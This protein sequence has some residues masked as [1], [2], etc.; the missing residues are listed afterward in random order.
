MVMYTIGVA[1]RLLFSRLTPFD[2]ERRWARDLARVAR[3][4]VISRATH[5]RFYMPPAVISDFGRRGRVLGIFLTIFCP[6]TLATSLPV[7][8]ER[9]SPFDLEISA[10]LEHQTEGQSFFVSWNDIITLPT[11]ELEIQGEFVPGKQT[12]T[13]VMLKDLWGSLP[14]DAA[15]DTLIAYCTD[16]YFSIYQPGFLATQKPFIVVRINGAGPDEWP[17]EG[18]DFNPGPFVI[19]VSD[20][21]VPGT[22]D[23]LDVGHKRPWGVNNV[24][25]VSLAE[26][27]AP[28][29]SGP[30]ANLSKRGEDGREL[31]INSCSSCHEGPQ[32]LSGG[33]KSQRPFPILAVHAQHNEDFFRQY[34]RDP[35]SLVPSA[36]MEPHPHYSDEQLDALVAFITAEQSGG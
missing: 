28:A 19:S 17:P 25:F 18:L 4:R 5:L 31:W 35:K 30:W 15:H 6:G 16:G 12:I 34:V 23:I 10:G 22:Q 26:I 21:L 8:T 20:K 9:A 27:M 36:T 3:S 14:V 29:R 32:G 7:M 33:N 1:P 2:G 24:Q 13:I 11:S